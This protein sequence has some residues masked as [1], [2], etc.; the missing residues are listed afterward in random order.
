MALNALHSLRLPGA[1]VHNPQTKLRKP[2]QLAACGVITWATKACSR[3][4]GCS[5][6]SI[7]GCWQEAGWLLAR[8]SPLS[9]AQ[10]CSTVH[11]TSTGLAAGSVSPTKG[12]GSCHANCHF[13]S[14]SA[15]SAGGVNPRGDSAGN[16]GELYGCGESFCSGD[17][18]KCPTCLS[19]TMFL[20]MLLS[21]QGVAQD[22]RI[23]GYV[24]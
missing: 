18:D 4:K 14:R 24:I 10:C 11:N 21:S 6:R 16:Q 3:L 20:S 2:V 13:L 12:L 23:A 15:L 22:C 1:L 5:S 17:P 8:P 9:A 7:V 19:T